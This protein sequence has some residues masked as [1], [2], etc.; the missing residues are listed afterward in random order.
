MRRYKIG[1]VDFIWI[2]WFVNCPVTDPWG[3]RITELLLP[4]PPPPHPLRLVK[5]DFTKIATMMH[6]KSLDNFPY[7]RSSWLYAGS[8]KFSF[9]EIL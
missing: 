1:F 4:P 6:L 5:H 2:L 3:P 8:C 7:E 9:G